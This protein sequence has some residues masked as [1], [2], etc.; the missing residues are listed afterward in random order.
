M[1]KTQASPHRAY[2][3]ASESFGAQDEPDDQWRPHCD[4]ARQDHLFQGPARAYVNTLGVFGPSGALHEPGDLPELPPHLVYDGEGG[5]FP[6]ARMVMAEKQEGQHGPYQQTRQGGVLEEVYPIQVR[7]LGVGG[8][9]GQRGQAGRTY[10]EALA[11]GRR[12][13][14]Q[15]VQRIG[16]LADLRGQAGLLRDA[17]GVVGHGPVGVGGQGY[18]QGREHAHS[19]QGHAV[20]V[21]QLEGGENGAPDYEHGHHRALHPGGYAA[22]H[23]RGGP[24]SVPTRRLPW[25][26]R[27]C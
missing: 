18:A 9:Q 1:A 26:V 12:R 15:G 7:G 19:G 22:Y 5:P 20:E 14:A 2:E 21:R 13:I 11:R 16:A 6:P 25:W 8:Q 10:G 24:R 23:G 4:Q 27:S 3:Q 17:S